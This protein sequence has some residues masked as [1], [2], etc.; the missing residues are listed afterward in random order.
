MQLT[1]RQFGKS[2]LAVLAAG[3]LGGSVA[4]EGC[5]GAQVINEINVVLKQAAAIL[6]V[7]E[8]GATWIVPLQNAI[9]ALMTAEQ[10][11]QSGGTVQL[12]IDALDTIV[13]VTAVIPITAPYSP[14][15]DITVA[16]I[17][18]ILAALPP[19]TAAKKLGA[20]APDNQHIGRVKIQRH[21]YHSPAT[22]FRDQWNAAA[23]ANPMLA[24]AVLQ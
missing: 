15:I 21:R 19:S 11:W 5:T 23:K 4:L 17:E 8:P 9:A 22:D 16:G 10:T 12:V 1:R 7:V 20:T 14:L 13:A 24:G 6:A 3:S 18:A 2:S